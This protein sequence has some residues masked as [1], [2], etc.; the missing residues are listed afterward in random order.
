MRK[1]FAAALAGGTALS[2]ASVA[3][4][5]PPTTNVRRCSFASVSDPQ[6][7]GSQTGEVNGGPILIG[8]QTGHLICTIQVNAPT[9]AGADSCSVTGPE[10][11]GAVAAA[12]TCT[13]AT[14][15]DDNVYLCTEVNIGGVSWYLD[16][17]ANTPGVGTWSASADVACGLATNFKTPNGEEIDPLIC[18][19]LDDFFP[20]GDIV[21]PDP[22]GLFWD[23]PPYQEG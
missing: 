5:A 1:L 10:S 22:I 20:G 16:D 17:S 12:G 9:H 7:E 14:A 23:C 21:L 8:D 13:Y 6:V 11:T 19:Y 18:P 15:D 2:F 4:A 3:E